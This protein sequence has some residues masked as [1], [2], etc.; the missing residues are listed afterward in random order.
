MRPDTHYQQQADV[1]ESER[2]RNPQHA[3]GIDVMVMVPAHKVSLIHDS[4]QLHRVRY[5]RKGLK[6][7]NRLPN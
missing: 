1:S 4:I 7:S 5:V 6:L 3:N 2:Q